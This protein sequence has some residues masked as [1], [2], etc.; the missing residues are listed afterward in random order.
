MDLMGPYIAAYKKGEKEVT[1][2]KEMLVY[3]YRPSLKS[4]M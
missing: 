4:A 3:W 2:E 1:V